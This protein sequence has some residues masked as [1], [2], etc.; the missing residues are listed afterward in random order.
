MPLGVAA[1]EAS[2]PPLGML[3][4]LGGRGEMGSPS[5]TVVIPTHNRLRY[6][7]EA[8]GSVRAQT[9]LDWELVVVDDC[10]TDGTRDWLRSASE[11]PRI[12]AIFLE[13]NSERS[14]ARNRGL[15]ETRGRHVLFLDDDDRLAP[16]AVDRLTRALAR[17]P[18][19]LA[20]VGARLAFDDEGRRR[21]LSHPRVPV[22]RDVW[23]DVLIGWV[24]V[25]GQ[26]LWRTSVLRREGGWHEGLVRPE[27]QELFLRVSRQ[28]PVALIP[29]VVLFYRFH[30]GQWRPSQLSN[31]EQLLRST[32][33]QALPGKRRAHADQLLAA[34]RALGIAGEAYAARNGAEA[35]RA[36]GRVLWSSPELRTSPLLGPF[37]WAN[38]A[39]SA[40]MLAVGRDGF[41]RIR[42]VKERARVAA[43]RDVIDLEHSDAR[44]NIAGLSPPTHP[45]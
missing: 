42:R 26:V 6:L 19:A 1:L 43:G 27:D 9:F 28:G 16:R 29:H 32:H 13:R 24:A 3:D 35:L 4:E 10:S 23:P 39:K 18:K 22:V 40:V 34:R 20:A 11:D 38:L 31:T 41:E 15:A 12:R 5:V 33:I 36:Y 45:E 17:H 14:A 21:R 25:P 44:S 8:M 7:T 37:L 30:A 2:W